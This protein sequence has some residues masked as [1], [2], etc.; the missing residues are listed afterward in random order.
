M[1]FVGGVSVSFWVK[2][3]VDVWLIVWKKFGLL[4]MNL[5]N[6]FCFEIMFSDVVIC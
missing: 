6:L 3:L 2:V 1:G 4:L 5:N